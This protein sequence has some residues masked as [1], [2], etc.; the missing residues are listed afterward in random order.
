MINPPRTI[1]P[2]TKSTIKSQRAPSLGVAIL[3]AD[4]VPGMIGDCQVDFL[5]RSLPTF[6]DA[7]IRCCRANNRGKGQFVGKRFCVALCSFN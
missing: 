3:P 2:D 6:Y 4:V 7:A 1:K 5:H